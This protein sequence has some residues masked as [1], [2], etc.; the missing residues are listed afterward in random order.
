MAIQEKRRPRRIPK[1]GCFFTGLRL[2][3]LLSKIIGGLTILG[4]LIGF[5]KV[6]PGL[7]DTLRYLDQQFAQFVFILMTTYLGIF[8]GL[9]CAGLILVG[10]GFLFDFIATQPN[11][12]IQNPIDKPPAAA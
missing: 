10:L 11:E 12:A 2:A 3:G 1:E 4:G 5:I 9:G 6:A 8:V 7:I